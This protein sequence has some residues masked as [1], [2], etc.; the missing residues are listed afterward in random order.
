MAP[1]LQPGDRILVDKLWCNPNRLK[2]NDIVVY[3][4]AGPGSPPYITRVVGLP[5][6]EIEIKKE[7]VYVNGTKWNDAHADLTGEVRMPELANF[8]PITVPLDAFF[9]LG[10]NRRNAVD[11]R[12]NGP[13]PLS[14]LIG[15]ANFIYW[16]RE[17]KTYYQNHRLMYESG[18]I[19]WSRIGIC[20]E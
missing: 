17:R 2:R 12:L 19:A 1:T 18:P 7:E 10:D 3:R 15:R 16:S 20:L 8:V 13:I 5:G 14:D 11:S 9:V 4:S 6:D